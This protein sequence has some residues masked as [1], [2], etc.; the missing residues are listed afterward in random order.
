MNI[1]YHKRF[2]KNYSIRIEPNSKLKHQFKKRL[3]IFI[4]DPKNPLL[5]DNRLTGDL[6]EFRSFS[7][8]GNIRL[9]YQIIGQDL[10]LYDIG[11]HNQVY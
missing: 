4:I 6:K 2:L 9:I 3:N 1:R 5:K 8:S 10:L 11:T 7:I